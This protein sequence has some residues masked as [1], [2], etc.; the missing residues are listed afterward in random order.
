M[1]Y[2]LR[3]VFR[4]YKDSVSGHGRKKKFSRL[5][6]IMKKAMLPF[7]EDNMPIFGL[8]QQ[9]NAPLYVSNEVLPRF[10]EHFIRLIPW[11]ARSPD[12]NPIENI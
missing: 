11:R 8:H 7:V 10:N 5:C 1:G 2:G 9:H 6:E 3:R 12:L 4:F